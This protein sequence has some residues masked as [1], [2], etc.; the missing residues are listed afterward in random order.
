MEAIRKK[1]VILDKDIKRGFGLFDGA[2]ALVWSQD[3]SKIAYTTYD[4]ENKTTHIYTIDVGKLSLV[5]LPAGE[6]PTEKQPGIAGF[7]VLFAI[8]GLLTVAY[9]LRRR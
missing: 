8:A 2:N 9:P 6:T 5:K 7:E 4:R 1:K 3:G